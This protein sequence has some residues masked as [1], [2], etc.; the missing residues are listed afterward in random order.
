MGGAQYV[1]LSTA[2]NLTKAGHNV[3]LMLPDGPLFKNVAKEFSAEKVF[4]LQ[5]F[6]PFCLRNLVAEKNISVIYVHQPRSALYVILSNILL[7]VPIVLSLHNELIHKKVR[8]ARKILYLAFYYL[9]FS[10]VTKILV[11]SNYLKLTIKHYY[12]QFYNKIIVFY[13]FDA[14]RFSDQNDFPTKKHSLGFNR[15]LIIACIGRMSWEKGQIHLV[16]AFELLEF[17][18][19]RLWLIGDGVEKSALEYYVS[20]SKICNRV[21]FFNHIDNIE[22]ILPS[23]DILVAPSISESFGLSILEGLYFN[24]LIIASNVGGIPEILVNNKYSILCPPGDSFILA[25]KIDAFL[26]DLSVRDEY[27]DVGGRSYVNENYNVTFSI[28]LLGKIF[29]EAIGNREVL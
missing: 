29:Q 15:E 28:D 14:G 27:P 9:I 16:K 21:D 7:D 24:K 22:D 4:K 2:R 12:P 13:Y 3:Y 18:R 19:C 23:V 1:Y 8:F 11:P 17:S 6:N 20:R 5:F 25:K 10:F 26:F